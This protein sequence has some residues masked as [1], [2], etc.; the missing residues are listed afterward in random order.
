L[1]LSKIFSKKKPDIDVLVKFEVLP[2]H[3]AIV[4]DGN[5]RWAKGRGMPRLMG[6]R[7]G[8][9][10]LKKVVRMF[11]DYGVKYLTVYAFS[12][13]NWS[14]PKSEVDGLMKLLLE[15]LK[16]AEEELGTDNVRI[17]VIGDISKLSDEL[18]REIKRVEILT[19]KNDGIDLIIA[20]NYGGRD[21]IVNSVNKIIEDINSGYLSK[22]KITEKDISERL[23][24]FNIPDPDLLIRTSGEKR[25]SNYLLWQS[26]Y[27]ELWFTKAYWPDFGEKEIIEALN[28]YKNR[29][30]R[31]GGV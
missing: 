13:E 23:Y 14:R 30:R 28:E 7:A 27:S 3:V 22:D 21:E 25:I 1:F 26:A 31:F 5:G 16:N 29:K 15:Y 8:A 17:N 4:M 11:K 12:T 18:Q 9:K 20:L 2:E 24:T 6:H 10:N 19:S